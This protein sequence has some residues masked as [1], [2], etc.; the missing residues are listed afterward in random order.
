MKKL[1]LVFL[2][3]FGMLGVSL[4]QVKKKILLTVSFSTPGIMCEECKN[5]LEQYMLKEEG[6]TKVVADFKRKT[7]K[8]TYWTDRTTTEKIFKNSH[9]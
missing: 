4:A 2:M 7:T 8:L 3:V 1:M 5:I 6:V 9:C